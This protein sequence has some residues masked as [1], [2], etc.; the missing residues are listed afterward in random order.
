MKIVTSPLISVVFDA[1]FTQDLIKLSHYHIP[2]LLC[3]K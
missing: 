1:I 2:P 3:Y